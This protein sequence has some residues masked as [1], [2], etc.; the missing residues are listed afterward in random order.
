MAVSSPKLLQW[1]LNGRTKDPPA[2]KH[3][4]QVE[5][6]CSRPKMSPLTETRMAPTEVTA[7][8]RSVQSLGTRLGQKRRTGLAQRL[9]TLKNMLRVLLESLHETWQALISAEQI[10][11]VGRA[12]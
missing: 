10:L 4:L 6:G 7:S 2:G 1:R 11:N 12:E 5:T 3:L 9:E 8:L